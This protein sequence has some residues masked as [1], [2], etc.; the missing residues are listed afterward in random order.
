MLLR[1]LLAVS[2][3]T[4]FLLVNGDP[5]YDASDSILE[6]NV[7]TFNEAVY[8]SDKAHFVEFYSSW[9]G[10]CIAY[11]PTFKQFAR[12]LASWKPFVQVTGVDCADD[13]NMPLCR[14]H[15][16]FKHNAVDK[17]DGQVYQ[18]NKY[19]LDQ[20]ERDVAAYVQADYEKQ[21]HRLSEIFQPVDNSKSLADMWAS[22]GSVNF[23]GLAVQEN[24]AA[25]A[26]ALI[27]NFYKDRNVRILLARPQHPEVVKQLG[28]DASNRFLLYQRGEPSPVWT[29]P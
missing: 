27:I 25:M 3:L 22:A 7:D 16:F 6:L 14:E 28:A 13:K 19:E 10:A 26:W 21:K 5:L 9:C 18:G 11:A 15:S 23:L 20:M 1:C 2:C 4:L 12:R 29:S 8:N 17:D 24:P